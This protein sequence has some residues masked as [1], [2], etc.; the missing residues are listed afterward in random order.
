M[1]NTSYPQIGFGL[2]LR[3]P[4]Y[5]AILRDRPGVDWFEII[6]ENFLDAHGGYWEF[7][8]DLRRDYPLVMHGVG[9]SIGGN[10][11]LDQTYLAKLKK[12]EQFLHPAWVSDHLC[13]T[14]QGGHNTHD[15]LP[16]PY[17]ETMLRH[18]SAR[19]RQVQDFLGRPLVLENPST[20]LAFNSSTIPEWEFLARLTQDTGCGLLLD[21]NNVYVS[22]F[23]HGFDTRTYIDAIP[24][25]HIAQIHL[26]GH[27]HKGTHIIDTHDAPVA[28]PVW[29]LYAY[30]LA[31]KGRVSTLIE[32]DENIPPLET[33][34]TELAQA[35]LYATGAC[36]AAA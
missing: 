1:T 30:T 28:D 35:R 20:Y 21:V 27:C 19:V 4:H 23:N 22:A 14:S 31:Q 24:A 5:D 11:P 3:A 12:L 33:L 17:T 26:A 36:D 8:A 10:D 13:F 2:G 6:S 32:W 25:A 16:I 9:L 7:L 29:A 34:L 15:L 18:V